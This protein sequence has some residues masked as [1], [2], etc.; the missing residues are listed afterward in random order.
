MTSTQFP[1]GFLWGAATS[2]YQIEGSPLSDGAGPSI[3]HRFSHTP[4]KIRGGDVGDV[5]C[6]H[7]RRYAADVELMRALDLGGY[8]FSLS[9]SRIF[10]EGRGRANPAGLDFYA[11]LID[12]L[13]ERGIQP[14][15]TLYHWDLP[16]ALDDRGGWLNPDV[17]G[18]FQDYAATAFEAFGDRVRMW[19]TINEPW[20]VMDG[21]YLY[22]VNAPGH[23]NR[24][25]APIV[26]HHLLCAHAAAVRA[27][28]IGGHPGR[29]GLVVNLEPKDPATRSA[30]DL[31]A[32]DRADA[33]MNRQFLD[34]LYRG[35]YP[36][37][38]ADMFGEAWPEFPSHELATIR[39][40]C[41]YLG[42][43]YYTRKVVRHDDSAWP[44]GVRPVRTADAL[45]T[46]TDWEV[47]PASL[48]RTLCWVRE[49]YGD[50]PI[51][52]TEN[53]A[54]FRDPPSD[55][56]GV[57]DDPLRVQYLRDHLLAAHEAIQRGVDLRGYF[58]W[59]LL[60]NF[61]WSS[62]FSKAFGLVQVD[63]ASQRRTLKSSAHYYRDVIRTNGA[64]L[65]AALPTGSA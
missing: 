52:V 35:E 8:R 32:V 28:R 50:V 3:W 23:S 20:V 62:G 16:A 65:G 34:P 5:A 37:E 47:H 54:A 22:G 40:P 55:A 58:V 6:D 14:A 53:G 36:R 59:S 25:E 38:L 15:V 24:F 30:E 64:S 41:D 2:A 61:E 57:V 51:Y 4:G 43:N 45:Y 19:S 44:V 60:D 42:V 56:E 33:Y 26:T 29:I 63:F 49:R 11:R 10:P 9:W 21:G 7:Y 39:E 13:L 12:L 46:E 1:D 18:W 17:V 48:T 31:A 27:F